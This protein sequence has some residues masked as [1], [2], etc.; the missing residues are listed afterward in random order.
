[1]NNLSIPVFSYE[2]LRKRA[3]SF[4]AKHHP[5]RKIPVPIE[6]IVE[7]QMGI[8][9]IPLPNLHDLLEIDGFVSGDL[10]EISV[11][12]FVYNKRPSR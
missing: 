3:D 8:N 6:E 11:D 12:E 1:L 7:L 9:I 10:K 4:L 5:S 2:D